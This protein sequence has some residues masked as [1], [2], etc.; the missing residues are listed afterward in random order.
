MAPGLNVQSNTAFINLWVPGNNTINVTC[1][2]GIATG[3]GYIFRNISALL[4]PTVGEDAPLGGSTTTPPTG[5][6]VSF[7]LTSTLLAT[8][9]A[10]P[11]P[12]T[13]TVYAVCSN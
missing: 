9:L 10:L 11:T 7:P 3:G 5:W 1:P 12:P 8:L 2:S 13:V 4:L 6:Q